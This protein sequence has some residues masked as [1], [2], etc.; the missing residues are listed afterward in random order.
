MA[1]VRTMG[2]I[3]YRRGDST[4]CSGWYTVSF[5]ERVIALHAIPEPRDDD[6]TIEWAM[7]RGA[8]Q[9]DVA[10]D[11][12]LYLDASER[13]WMLKV[14]VDDPEGLLDLVRRILVR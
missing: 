5:S 8:V 1:D 10:T 2:G 7:V 11:V 3:G 9:Q 12:L 6:H 13:R 14:A 4:D